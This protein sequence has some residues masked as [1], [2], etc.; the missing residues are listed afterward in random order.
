MAYYYGCC[1]AAVSAI[2]DYLVMMIPESPLDEERLVDNI[3][4]EVASHGGIQKIPQ[5]RKREVAKVYRE[6]EIKFKFQVLL[7]W[8]IIT[9]IF[10]IP[11]IFYDTLIARVSACILI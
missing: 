2:G 7:W 3:P 6:I 1:D 5:V 10:A 11:T 9:I 4:Q 8:V